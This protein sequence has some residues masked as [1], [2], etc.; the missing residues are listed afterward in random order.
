[1]VE[2]GRRKKKLRARG[3][4]PIQ[5]VEQAVPRPRPRRDPERHCQR[6]EAEADREIWGGGNLDTHPV[7]RARDVPGERAQWSSASDT[8]GAGWHPSPTLSPHLVSS[9]PS[10]LPTHPHWPEHRHIGL[11]TFNGRMLQTRRPF[12][13]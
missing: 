11:D 2:L 9:P 8:P 1:M 7:P 6:Q 13:G 3:T 10:T 5:L 4:T 12:P